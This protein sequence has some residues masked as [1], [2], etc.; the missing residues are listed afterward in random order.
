[1]LH[2]NHVFAEFYRDVNYVIHILNMRQKIIKIGSTDNIFKRFRF[3]YAWNFSH[4]LTA[5]AL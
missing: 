3:I 5:L 1:M 2:M 4:S